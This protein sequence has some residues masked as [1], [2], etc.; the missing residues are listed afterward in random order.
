MRG[1]R[2]RGDETGITGRDDEI[3]DLKRTGKK[4]RK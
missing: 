2:G 4:L 1:G 3:E